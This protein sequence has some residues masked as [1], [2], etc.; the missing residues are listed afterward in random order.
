MTEEN[1]SEIVLSVGD[2]KR[3]SLIL[4]TP[5]GEAKLSFRRLK[6][7]EYLK[8]MVDSEKNTKSWERIQEEQRMVF[9]KAVSV[10]GLFDDGE[11]VTLEQLQAGE[12]S[13]DLAD[14][15]LKGF[16]LIFWAEKGRRAESEAAEKKEQ[17]KAEDSPPD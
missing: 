7:N 15:I 4:K 17:E 13:S 5:E 2:R 14:A 16:W 3:V 12:V 8:L 11:A 10:E 9:T 1:T 6:N